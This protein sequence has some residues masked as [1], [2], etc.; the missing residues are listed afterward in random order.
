MKEEEDIEKLL[1][2]ANVNKN[3]DCCDNPI[4]DIVDLSF[5]WR[6]DINAFTMDAICENC[7]TTLT[8]KINAVESEVQE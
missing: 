1:E 6:S 2:E 7:W 3:A 4:I 8:V 5:G